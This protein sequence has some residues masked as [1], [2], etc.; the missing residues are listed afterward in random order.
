M[1]HDWAPT[2]P[3][4]SNKPHL[5][6]PEDKAHP[7]VALEARAICQGC[8]ARRACD[9]WATTNNERGIWGGRTEQD[10]RKNIPFR[11]PRVYTCRYCQ[12]EFLSDLAYRA[13]C[14]SETCAEAHARRRTNAWR[15][16]PAQKQAPRRQ[17]RKKAS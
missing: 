7:D 16:K 8:P 9:D 5:F 10:R 4:C 17:L 1:K 2:N 15:A 13:S 14:G 6:F 11:A 3:P 12:R